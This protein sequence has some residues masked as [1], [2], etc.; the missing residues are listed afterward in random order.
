MVYNEN[1]DLASL[2]L[3]EIPMSR[4]V[5]GNVNQQKA[6]SWGEPRSPRKDIYNKEPMILIV[7]TRLAIRRNNENSH[8]I[9]FWKYCGD[10]Q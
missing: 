1:E 3:T 7:R 6:G 8:T 9:Y 10:P 2:K 5:S 4:E